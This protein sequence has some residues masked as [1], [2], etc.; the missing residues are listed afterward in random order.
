MWRENRTILIPKPGRG[1]TIGSLLARIHSGIFD[2]RLRQFVSFAD[3]QIGFSNLDGYKNNIN[4]DRQIGFSNLDDCK[5]NINLLWKAFSCMRADYGRVITIVDIIKAFD[6]NPHSALKQ[7]LQSKDE[8]E[9]IASHLG[10]MY[11]DC[12]TTL[13]MGSSHS[14]KI[15][16]KPSVNQ[17]N[18]L[19]PL[20]LN[21]TLDPMIEAINSGTTGID[22]ARKN[23]RSGLSRTILCR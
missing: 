7:C 17:G 9:R 8:S 6:T 5:N 11:N 14:I 19:S 18:P 10:L 21:V 3:G 20:L 15:Q 13:R 16:L 4:A 12:W 23:C 2:R 22:M 1:A